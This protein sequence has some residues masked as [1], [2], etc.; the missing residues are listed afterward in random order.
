MIASAFFT[1]PSGSLNVPCDNPVISPLKRDAPPPNIRLGEMKSPNQSFTSHPYFDETDEFGKRRRLDS[2]C[3][4]SP[5]PSLCNEEVLAEVRAIASQAGLQKD[6]S[7]RAVPPA[8]LLCDSKPLIAEQDVDI[9]HSDNEQDCNELGES[10]LQRNLD[11]EL[12]LIEDEDLKVKI[13]LIRTKHNKE[14]VKTLKEMEKSK[15][16]QIEEEKSSRRDLEAQVRILSSELSCQKRELNNIT[17]QMIEKE[18]QNEEMSRLFTQ[19]LANSSSFFT[20]TTMSALSAA[21]A[22]SL[23][24][25][26][27]DEHRTK[28]EMLR[29][30]HTLYTWLMNN[31]SPQPPAVSPTAGQYSR[32]QEELNAALTLA[33]GCFTAPS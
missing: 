20:P 32:T 29:K 25:S 2:V 5:K 8:L 16:E 10:L 30:R 27:P 4:S 15:L 22:G 3:G 11:E 7:L 1:G 12:A 6:S 17:R 21:L 24:S 9:E 13:K 31:T 18:R 19:L 28:D 26:S 14:L 23:A 33:S